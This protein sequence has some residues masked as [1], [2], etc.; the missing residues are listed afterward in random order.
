MQFL[1]EY[2]WAAG[3]AGKGKL[4]SVLRLAPG[5]GRKSP[6]PGGSMTGEDFLFM[7]GLSDDNKE[8]TE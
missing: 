8:R 4:A 6:D 5:P 7:T 2:L 1:E 3:R